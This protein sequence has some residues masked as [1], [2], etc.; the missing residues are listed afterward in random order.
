MA[1]SWNHI[2]TK[3]GKFGGTRLIE[4][5]GDAYEA[6]EECYGMIQWLAEQLAAAR[7]TSPDSP[8]GGKIAPRAWWIGMAE[9][10]CKD[11]L[12]IGG[13]AKKRFFGE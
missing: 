6:L 13:Q 7:V 5:L 8:S 10:H 11:G 9:R 3:T 2:V 1:G 12:V 4:N